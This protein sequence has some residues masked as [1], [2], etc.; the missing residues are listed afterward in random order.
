LALKDN[1]APEVLGER[2]TRGAA[3]VDREEDE[4]C[5]AQPQK[6]RHE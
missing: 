1:A 6:G 3:N 2:D 4:D 5:E